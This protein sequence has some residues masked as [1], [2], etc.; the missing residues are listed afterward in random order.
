MSMKSANRQ[1]T[2]TG[3]GGSDGV[4]DTTAAWPLTQ[5]ALAL[6][7][8]W[9]IAVLVVVVVGALSQARFTREP[10]SY[11]T[12][13]TLYIVVTPTGTSTNYDSYQAA[14]WAETI[15]H[16]LAEG[17]LTTVSGGFAQAINVQLAGM[18]AA[19]GGPHNLTSSQFQQ[20]LSWSNYG[21]QVVLTASWT[22]PG[23]ATRLLSAT[24]TALEEG[25]LTHVTI[26]RGELPPSMVAHVVTG[27]VPT[28]PQLNQQ[29]HQAEFE[30][31]V[32][33]R[34]ALS[35]PAGIFLIFAWDWLRRR[36]RKE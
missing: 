23:G 13:Q 22:S 3:Q 24:V 27:G 11:L 4:P 32:L 1:I 31:L 35:L 18:T 34:L 5:M 25:D 19:G 8:G 16:A 12:S 30:Q 29:Q 6:R 9:W 2:S 7:R 10:V 28:P 33:A 26:W 36:M 17:R 14:V 15:G 20:D 21:N